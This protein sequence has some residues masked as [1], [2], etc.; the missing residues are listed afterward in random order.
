[1][2]IAQHVQQQDVFNGSVKT[3]FDSLERQVRKHQ[4]NF[5][6]VVMIFQNRE[7]YIVRNGAVADEMAQ[8]I[9]ALIEDAEKKRLWIGNLMKESQA[10]EVLKQ[11]HMGQQVLAEAM[12]RYVFQ[13]E[14]QQQQPQ[15]SKAITGA[16]PPVTEVDDDDDLDRLDFMGGPNPHKGPPNS[17]TVQITAKPPRTRKHKTTPKRK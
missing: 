6:E 8:Y 2:K 15:P 17:G 10:Q 11:H 14:Q 1:M 12:K 16:G 7:K 13:R 3:S 5:Q 4:D 9:N